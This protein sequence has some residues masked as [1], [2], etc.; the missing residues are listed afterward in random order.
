MRKKFKVVALT[1]A[2]ALVLAA[3]GQETG[4]TTT[5]VAEEPTVLEL[6]V[7]AGQFSTL[8]AAI[9]AAGLQDT[10]SG[11][12]PFTVFA[13]TDAAF[14]AAFE[15]LGMTA[16]ELLAD[17]ETLTQ[18]LTYHVL[19]Q[20][21][22][23]QLVATLDGQEVETV[24]GQSIRVSVTDGKVMVNEAEVVSADLEAS[25]GV[26]H[27]INAVLLPPDIAE[28]LVGGDDM[29]TTTTTEATTTTAAAASD[30][31]ADLVAGN[32]DFSILLA[33]VEAAGLT[34]A[35]AD[36]EA[37]LTVFAPTDEA[38]E[39][40]LQTL[41]ITAEELLADTETL[42]T[43]L[44]YHVYGEV[45]TSTD[46]AGAG[47]EEVPVEML[48]GEELVILVGDDGSVSFKDQTAKVVSADVTASNGVVH[49]VDAVLL[50][51]S[52]AG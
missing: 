43:I 30:T 9:E 12:G 41:G 24:N 1:L 36:P 29:E 34:D 32:E 5:T 49:V 23:S 13:P 45:V 35:I 40:A 50:P 33:A 6:A 3:C 44:T 21:A 28:A 42:T 51:P 22:N 7:E 25:N 17:T 16:E 48:S 11:E 37:T 10:L 15:A 4:E 27:V 14:E 47:M 26:V 39:A 8:V 18:I 2:L 31:I 38:F 52:I 19:P 46:L 20:E